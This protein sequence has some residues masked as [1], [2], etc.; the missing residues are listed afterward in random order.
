MVEMIAFPARSEA[1]GE[2][3][4]KIAMRQVAA[5]VA[6]VTARSGK[7]R[8]GL[9]A[10][11]V[12]SVAASPP[13]MLVCINRSASAEPLIQESGAFAI[14]FLT[15]GQ[16]GI[17]RLFST[18]KLAPED[19]FVEGT[20]GSLETGAPV[21]EGTVA[22]FDCRVESQLSSGTH[23]IYLGRVVGVTSL[24]MDVLLYRDGS[25]RRLESA[26]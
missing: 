19:R 4:F 26:G 14:N 24:D 18:S 3:E 2:A 1:V 20:W 9:T 16:H 25:F 12:C 15:D 8:N 7:L 23:H 22:S 11:A 17:A 6:I 10:T 5:S 13:T 21:L